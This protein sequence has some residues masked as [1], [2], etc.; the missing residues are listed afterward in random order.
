MSHRIVNEVYA[1]GLPVTWPSGKRLVFMHLAERFN[2]ATGKSYPGI[3]EM[4]RVTGLAKGTIFDYIKELKL[5]G[6]V[7]R[8]RRGCPGQRAEYKVH[9]PSIKSEIQVGSIESIKRVESSA[10]PKRFA[11][12]ARKVMAENRYRSATQDPKHINI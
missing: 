4:I 12:E 1:K 2:E 11:E 7:S 10:N 9:F 6:Y 3:E 8:V 5:E